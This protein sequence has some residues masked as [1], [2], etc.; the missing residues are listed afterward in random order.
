[1]TS[2]NLNS[3][4]ATLALF[5]LMFSFAIVSTAQSVETVAIF[6]KNGDVRF[7]KITEAKDNGTI[8]LINECGIYHIQRSEIDSIKNINTSSLKEDF[9]VAGSYNY[10]YN[11]ATKAPLK[12]EY[13]P[14]EKGFYNIT[15]VALLFGQGQ[16]GFLPVPSLSTVNGWQFNKR[17]L[18]GIGISYEYYEWS[19]LP[20]FAEVKYMLGS[21]RIIPY[22]SLKLGYGFPISSPSD[23]YEDSNGNITKYY[24]GIQLNPE[25]GIRI[26][27][28][29]KSSFLLSLGYHFQQL[30]YKENNYYWWNSNNFETTVHTDFNRI[31]VRAGFM[32]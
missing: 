9:E 28:S 18:T 20:V 12:N 27:L 26:L 3:R 15:S 7:G 23:Y 5:L 22:G 2:N 11:T 29:N 25:A 6:L 17:L 13:K 24:G 21:E 8:R 32:F 16:N 4:L 30:S 10:Q 31:S 14:S 1:M 19:V